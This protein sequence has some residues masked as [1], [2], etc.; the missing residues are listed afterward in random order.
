MCYNNA[1]LFIPR[2]YNNAYVDTTHGHLVVDGGGHI[3]H[4]GGIL[5][6]VQMKTAHYRTGWW[7]LDKIRNA[8]QSAYT[9]MK[10]LMYTSHSR[11]LSSIS[12]TECLMPACNCTQHIHICSLYSKLQCSYKRAAKICLRLDVWWLYRQLY[13]HSLHWSV[14]DARSR[15]GLFKKDRANPSEIC[16]SRVHE[17]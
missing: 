7:S 17:C 14:H 8:T 13:S 9:T 12:Y 5:H 2:C 1:L 16:Q 3:I 15:H 10:T 11:H 6:S 4:T